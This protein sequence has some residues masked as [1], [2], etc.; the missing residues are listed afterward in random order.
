MITATTGM[1]NPVTFHA[2]IKGVAVYLDYWALKQLAKGDVSR[3]QRFVSAIRSGG[4]LI[5]SIANAAELTGPQGGSRKAL[6][7]F[8][9]E[10]GPHWF[11]VELNPIIVVDRESKGATPPDSCVV[12]DDFMKG[13]FAARTKGYSPGSGR[14]ID[15]SDQFFSLGVF[16]D[17]TSSQRDSMRSRIE[18]LD[19]GMRKRFG[20][21][22][23]ELELDPRW[24]DRHVP[25]FSFDP[26]RPASF[27]LQHLVRMLV[28]EAKARRLK[29][30]DGIDFCHAVIASSFAHIAA[31]DKHW[32]R[33]VESLPKPNNLALI[34]YEPELDQM[35]TELESCTR[36]RRL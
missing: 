32:K 1:G 5:F 12:A 34:Y 28:I 13:Y 17:W 29:K 26:K 23:R 8:L 25:T 35:V 3:R 20:A 33:R 7:D 6:K 9:D 21:Y 36:T 10:L 30:G 18:Y 11:P 27:A 4:D 2:T 22:R 19:R 14:I 31:L 24:L 16:V 15:L